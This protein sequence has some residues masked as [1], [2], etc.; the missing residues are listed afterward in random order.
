MRIIDL[1]EAA[2]QWLREAR[3]MHEDVDLVL[4]RVYWRSGV[5]CGGIWEGGTWEG[6]TWEGGDWQGG[7]WWGGD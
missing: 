4:G 5:W 6:G 7:V 3:T 1:G 2:P